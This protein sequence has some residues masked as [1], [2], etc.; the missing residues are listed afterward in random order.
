MANNNIP[1]RSHHKFKNS[2]Q[3]SWF[4]E[5]VGEKVGD[6]REYGQDERL[7]QSRSSTPLGRVLISVV[8]IFSFLAECHNEQGS[9]DKDCLQ[10][11][12]WRFLV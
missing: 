1:H 6:D 8:T 4:L 12:S 7:T 2:V 10:V 5:L 9:E 11:H 3:V